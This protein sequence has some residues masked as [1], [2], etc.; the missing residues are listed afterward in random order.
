[1]DQNVI[2]TDVRGSPRSF[3]IGDDLRGLFEVE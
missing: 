2:R 3:L 1:V